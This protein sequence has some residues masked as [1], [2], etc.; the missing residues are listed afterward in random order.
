MSGAVTTAG[1]ATRREICRKHGIDFGQTYIPGIPGK[2]E[3]LWV[4]ACRECEKELRDEL[5]AAEE[6][7]KQ[8]AE[9]K[10][11]AE[12]RVAA[13]S[14]FEERV[15]AAAD[16][17]VQEEVA[18]KVARFAAKVAQLCAEW[19]PQLEEYHRDLEWNRVVS[20]IEAERSAAII[21]R[22]KGRGSRLRTAE[23]K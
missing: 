22:L 13:D 18:A 19:R 5:L 3:S 7:S 4:G 14:Q 11:E 16:A 20:E 6:I 12:R 23:R 8:A 9:I 1:R 21:S 17:E 15:R 10:S 2:E